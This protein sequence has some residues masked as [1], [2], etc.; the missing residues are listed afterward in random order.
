[1]NYL[2]LG[3]DSQA[4]DIKITELKKQI[5]PSRE[6][7]KF[8]Y[9]V[10]HG[11]KLKAETLKKALVSLPAISKKR[12]LLIR[13]CHKCKAREKGLITDFILKP[14]SP[15]VLVLDSDS[16]DENNVF[17]KKIRKNVTIVHFRQKENLDVFTLTRAIGLRRVADSLKILSQ[18]LAA[19]I[20]PLQIMG[21]LV[22]F[23]GHSRNRYSSGKFKEGL[24]ALQEAD[25]NIKRS[26]LKPE[27]ALELLIVK[28]CS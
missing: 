20:H 13:E 1:M 28:L 24:A 26:R 17:V 11:S 14:Y 21:G 3:E 23:W 18:L 6:S 9:E 4:K 7:L 8:D 12:L 25:T 2:F 10:L 16:L 22:W 19:G 15:T 27:Y 5:L